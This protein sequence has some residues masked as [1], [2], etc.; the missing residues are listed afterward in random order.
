MAV[1]VEQKATTKECIDGARTRVGRLRDEQLAA[2]AKARGTIQDGGPHFGDADPHNELDAASRAGREFSLALTA[3]EDA[4]MR[5]N[6]GLTMA[7]GV[8]NEVDLEKPGGIARAQANHA[9]NVAGNAE[10]T[11]QRS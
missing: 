2:A 4:T 7:A 11:A 6:R 9:A 10:S 1:T 5:L 8:Y 3:L